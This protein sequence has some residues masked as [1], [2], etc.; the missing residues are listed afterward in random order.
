MLEEIVMEGKVNQIGVCDF[1]MT[2]I[3]D[4]YEFAQVFFYHCIYRYIFAEIILYYWLNCN[5]FMVYLL[6]SLYLMF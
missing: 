5:S 2:E 6:H 1:D 4:L 3:E